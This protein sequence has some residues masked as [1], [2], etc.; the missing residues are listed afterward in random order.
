MTATIKL[1][2]PSAPLVDE[3]EFAALATHPERMRA[4]LRYAI[5][6]PS[7]HN[8]QPWKFRIE[9]DGIA[10]LDDRTRHLPI[11]DPERREA[12]LSIGAAV[13]NLRVAASRFGLYHRVR[14]RPDPTTP[15]LLAR[16]TFAAQG[17]S[18]SDLAGLFPAI[19]RRRTNRRPYRP[20]P[21]APGALQELHRWTAGCT[22]AIRLITEIEVRQR[23]GELVDQGDRLQF[24]DPRFRDELAAWIRTSWTREGDGMPAGSLGVP[25]LV[26]PA[27]PWVVRKFNLGTAQGRTHHRLAAE[28]PLLAVVCGEDTV[29]SWLEAGE[30]LER[31]L[32]VATQQGLQHAFMNQPVELHDLRWE[33]RELLSTSLWPQLVLRLGYARPTRRPTPRR[34]LEAVLAP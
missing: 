29:S 30:M 6:A 12:V 7:G 13:M 3:V 9:P 20:R 34:D 1:E 11:V 18:D 32:L 14:Y 5:L 25:E 26:S 8:L 17:W 2:S 15:E 19:V 22:A 31:F 27:G 10:V 28:A 24:A 16:V 21:L 23:I 4:L 33:L